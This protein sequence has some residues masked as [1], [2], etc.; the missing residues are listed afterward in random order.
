MTSLA[1]LPRP[2]SSLD[3]LSLAPPVGTL[4][5]LDPLGLNARSLGAE[6]E[7]GRCGWSSGGP[8][9]RHAHEAADFPFSQQAL[10]TC[11]LGVITR[12]FFRG[13][14][15]DMS[16]SPRKPRT[17]AAQGKCLVTVT[18]ISILKAQIKCHKPY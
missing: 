17:V 15:A 11:P 4:G 9:E 13:Q 12:T 14:K 18:P 2:L 1:H 7:C 5:P 8:A 3:A 10:L 6:Q 16:D